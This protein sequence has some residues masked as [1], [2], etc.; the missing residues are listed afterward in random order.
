MRY[1]G[2]K[3]RIANKVSWQIM[4]HWDWHTAYIEPFVGSC[5]ITKWIADE[6][7]VDGR[8]TATDICPD[9][10]LL[11]EDLQAGWDPPTVVTK[12]QYEY[13]RNE[14][15]SGLRA[16]IGFGCSYGGK[17]FGGYARGDYPGGK[18]RNYASQARNSLLRL[19]PYIARV[20]FFCCDYADCLFAADFPERALIYCDPPYVG[21][22]AYR[23]TELFDH[24]RFWKQCRS[25]AEQGH[26]VLVSEYGAPEDVQ[27]VYE[28]TRSTFVRPKG[29][30][31]TRNEKL[32]LVGAT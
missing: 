8:V 15:P 14:P 13:Y 9:L 27:Q 22:T 12:E 3:T 29:G 2:G 18:V 31:E 17:F 23:G 28:L 25:W 1:L 19:V 7:L 24:D 4:T 5:A 20:K 10:V 11:Y 30:N 6:P 16:F 26:T 21:T 32:F